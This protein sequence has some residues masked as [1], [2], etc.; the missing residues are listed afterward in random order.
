M[1][2]KQTPR[3]WYC[4]DRLTD[5]YRASIA[6]GEGGDLSM[7]KLLKLLRSLLVN[8]G[9]IG[10]AAYALSL[11]AD[12]TLIGSIALVVLGG[13]NGLEIGDYLSALQ[14]YAEVQSEQ[15]NEK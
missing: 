15:G 9:I 14:A 3:P 7:F 13:Y 10:L 12:P 8:S 5:D 2:M 1:T 4:S 6:R 11:G